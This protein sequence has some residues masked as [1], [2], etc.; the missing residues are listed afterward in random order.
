MKN[1]REKI[2]SSPRRSARSSGY[3]D[4]K[5]DNHDRDDGIEMNQYKE[6]AQK[7]SSRKNRGNRKVR[8]PV[9]GPVKSRVKSPVRKGRFSTDYRGFNTSITDMYKYPDKER[10]DCCSIACFGCLQADRNRYVVNGIKPPTLCRRICVHIMLPMFLFGMALFVA[11]NVP[12]PVMNNALCYGW[13]FVMLLYFVAQCDKGSMK[14]KDIRRSLLLEK[15]QKIASTRTQHKWSRGSEDTDDSSQSEYEGNDEYLMG[16]THSDI[17]NASGMCGCYCVDRQA[18]VNAHEDGEITFCT[19]I[20]SCLTNACCGIC[21]FYAMCCGFCSV[22]QEGREIET[23]VRP[24]VLSIDYVTMQPMMEY[25]QKIYEARH[26]NVR[27]RSSWYSRLSSFSRQTVNNGILTLILLFGWSLLSSRMKHKFGPKNYI[28]LFLTLLQS[29]IILAVVYWKHTKDVSI[30]ALVKFFAAGFCLS[31]TLAVFFELVLGLI[32]RCSMAFIMAVSGI[33]LVEGNGYQLSESLSG[34]D[35]NSMQEVNY[36]GYGGGYYHEYLKAYGNEHPF[37]YTVYLFVVTF[38]LAALIEE[39]CKYFGY[40]M[41]DHPD[42]YTEAEIDEAVEC[43]ENDEGEEIPIS[44]FSKQN[45]SLRSRGAAITVSMVAVGTGFACCENLVYI[46]IYG[47]AQYTSEIFLLLARSLFPVHPI[48]AALQSIQ[49]CRR[50]LEKEKLR[51]GRIILP[52]IIFHGFYDFMLVWIYYIGSRKGNY[53][54][55][56]GGIATESGAAM[57]S[58]TMSFFVLILG[59]LYYFGASRQQRDRLIGLDRNA[60]AHANLI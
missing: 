21:G 18:E 56:D 12:D 49:V 25:Y 32:V 60:A 17:R 1:V 4:D 10:V 24:G 14:R 16:Q 6:F 40:R 48:A 57:F 42:F 5:D 11:F 36:A 47:K 3:D 19:R 59:L 26:S 38:I 43:Y 53:Y 7:T 34:N 37:V 41:V 46:F 23:L 13:M 55:D 29:F 52:G 58:K 33:D 8:S 39:T 28:V 31:T 50:E 9:R 15:Y 2:I 44:S 27:P 51:L 22:A 30:D 54:D 35:L 20:F 45:R